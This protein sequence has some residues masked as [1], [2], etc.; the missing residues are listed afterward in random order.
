MLASLIWL[1]HML[2]ILWVV[3]TP[4]TDNEPMLVLHALVIPFL[5]LHWWLM[6][7]TCFLTL[8]EQ[9]LRG[10]PADQVPEKS[11]FFKLVSPVYKIKDSEVRKGA[12][13]ASVVLWAVT[14]RKVL[15][16]PAMIREV[17]TN[18]RHAVRGDRIGVV[19]S[20]PVDGGGIVAAAPLLVA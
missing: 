5:W 4:F 11:F 6:D 19:D 18:A 10:L 3:V 20:V 15:R 9:R 8:V 1:L 12:W 2:F 16:R 14:V 17:F 13:I 7:D